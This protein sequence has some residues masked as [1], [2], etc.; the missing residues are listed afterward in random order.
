MFYYHSF[1]DTVLCLLLK[2]M[3]GFQQ[4]TGDDVA[5]TPTI[6]GRRGRVNLIGL[7]NGLH[8]LGI[9]VLFPEELRNFLLSATSRLALR[10]TEPYLQRKTR[11]FSSLVKPSV[12]ENDHSNLVSRLRLSIASVVESVPS[13][14]WVRSPANVQNTEFRCGFFR[15]G[16]RSSG[17][18]HYS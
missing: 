16:F 10:P 13:V 7:C 4:Q 17:G 11:A 15:T 1:D 9:L 2:W 6:I 3:L 14:Q 18:R 12:R 5:I 8:D